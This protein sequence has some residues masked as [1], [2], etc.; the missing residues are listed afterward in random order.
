[1]SQK[2]T[3]IL[4]TYNEL[5][6]KAQERAIQEITRVVALDLNNTGLGNQPD[7]PL[8]LALVKALSM[9]FTEKGTPVDPVTLKEMIYVTNSQF[10]R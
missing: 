8:K 6:G 2:H 9:L 10:E 4:Y 1:M 5:A 7:G 3:I